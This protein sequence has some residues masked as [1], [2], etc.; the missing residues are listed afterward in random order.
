MNVEHGVKKLEEV[1][2]RMNDEASAN[3][4]PSPERVTVREFIAWFGFVRR[5]QWLVNFVRNKMEQLGIRTVP[6]FEHIWIDSEI[7]IEL[8][9]AEGAE[10]PAIPDDPSVRIGMLEAANRKPVRIAPDKPISEATT[11]MLMNDYSQLPV[12]TSD[13]EVKGVISWQSIGRR[14]TLGRPYNLVRECMDPAMEIDFNAPLVDAAKGI[15]EHQYVLVRGK[16]KE[17]TGIVTSSDI[18]GQFMELAGTFFVIGEIEGYLRLIV[19]G[20]FTTDELNEASLNQDN[21]QSITGPANLTFGAYCQLLGKQDRWDRLGLKIDRG[22]FVKRLEVVR[23]IRNDV[24]HFA[25]DGLAPEH[26]K[27]LNDLARFFRD[28]AG[29]GVI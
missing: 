25:P 28:L 20:K 4:M 2:N 13:W 5:S 14:L 21:K 24:M 19:K 8:V 3:A 12:M 29:M 6:D 10:P 23:D 1:A 22:E 16:T 18:A 11:V 26:T 15:L 17:I 9:P 7:S 27:A